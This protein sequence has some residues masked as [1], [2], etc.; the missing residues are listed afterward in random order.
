MQGSG[1]KECPGFSCRAGQSQKEVGPGVKPGWRGPLQSSDITIELECAARLLE[2]S[3]LWLEM[4]DL[5]MVPFNPSAETMFAFVPAQVGA[6]Y[7][8][9]I[10]KQKWIGRLCVAQAGPSGWKCETR[11]PIVKRRIPRRTGIIG[12]GNM[13]IIQPPC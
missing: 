4:V 13:Q 6:S 1:V 8:L 2:C 5:R 12:P 11:P 7:K 10:T 9:L 3:T